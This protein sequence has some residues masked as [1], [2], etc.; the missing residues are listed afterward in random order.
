[1]IANTLL[2]I[3]VGV[4]LEVIFTAACDYRKT[5][6]LPLIAVYL[7][8]VAQHLG[9]DFKI[10]PILASSCDLQDSDPGERTTGFL[11]ELEGLLRD[12]PGKV[13]L[14]AGVDFALVAH[15]YGRRS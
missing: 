6:D 13:C 14:L 2:L 15:I 5:R 10:L 3:C 12:Y 7:K 9:G 1:M 4:T 11:D 8:Y